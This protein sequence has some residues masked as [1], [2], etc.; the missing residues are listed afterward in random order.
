MDVI[1]VNESKSDTG[2]I[3]FY[4]TGTDTSLSILSGKCEGRT[5]LKGR[6]L[7]PIAP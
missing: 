7:A 3:P 5:T 2:N 4:V 1:Y 6:F